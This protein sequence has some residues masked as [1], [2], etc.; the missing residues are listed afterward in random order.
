PEKARQLLAEAGVGNLTLRFVFDSARGP[1]RTAGEIIRDNLRQVGLDLQ[2]V[3]LERSVMVEEVYTRRAFDLSMQSFTSAGDP[4]LGYHRIYMSAAPGTPFVNATGYS[5]PQ[6][7][8]L[9]QE[10]TRVAD[11]DQR[12][13]LYRQAAAILAQDLPVLV[14]FDELA[15]E[16]S[17]KR[18]RG[19]REALDVRD[20]LERVWWA[21]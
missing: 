3:P 15:T 12:A 17:D 13:E 16:V 21:E 1:F 20:R 4:I 7:D 2:L 5:N 10:A 8:A 19:M 9:L 14:L 11:L 6:V 18:L